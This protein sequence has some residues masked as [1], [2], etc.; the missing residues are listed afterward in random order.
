[1]T[2][3][4]ARVAVAWFTAAGDTP[5]LK[6]AFSDDGGARFGDPV[7]IDDGRPVG[8]PDLVILEDGAVLVSWLERRGEG[9]GEVLLRRVASGGRPG[10]PLVVAQ[11]V[12]GRATGA[13]HMVRSGDRVV[14]AWRTDRVLTASV[15]VAA[16]QP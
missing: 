2:A 15:P 16:I 10:P 13:P 5:R 7:V 8:W 4:D 9:I 3:R 1:V 14:V 11:A 12:S 6:L